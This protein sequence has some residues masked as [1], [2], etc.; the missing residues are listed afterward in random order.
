MPNVTT[1]IRKDDMEKWLAC[2]NKAELI[3]NAL[4]IRESYLAMSPEQKEHVKSGIQSLK[5]D[6][7]DDPE[8]PEKELS[9][10][11]MGYVYDKAGGCIWDANGE[12]VPGKVDKNGKITAIL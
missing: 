6:T 11:E 4:N 7:I 3:H 12:Q 1:Y 2:P 8:E 10:E 5:E 9:F